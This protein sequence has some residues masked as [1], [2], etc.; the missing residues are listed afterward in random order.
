MLLGLKQA[1]LVS[2]LMIV[3]GIIL[4]IVRAK[5][6]KFENKYNEIGDTSEIRF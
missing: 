5:G 3:I 6:S 2:I 4:I 1:Q